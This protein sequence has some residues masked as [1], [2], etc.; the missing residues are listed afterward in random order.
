MGQTMNAQQGRYPHHD[1]YPHVRARPFATEDDEAPH[2]IAKARHACADVTAQREVLY[3]RNLLQKHAH[4]F[5]VSENELLGWI[6]ALKVVDENRSAF[7]ALAAHVGPSPDHGLGLTMTNTEQH[8][9][10]G[11]KTAQRAEREAMPDHDDYATQEATENEE[12]APD[13]GEEGAGTETTTAAPTRRGGPYSSANWFKSAKAIA[14]MR[15]LAADG[16]SGE[17]AKARRADALLTYARKNELQLSHVRQLVRAHDKIEELRPRHPEFA[18]ALETHGY[19]LTLDILAWRPEFEEE[20]LAGARRVIS[21]EIKGRDFQYLPTPEQRKRKPKGEAGEDPQPKAKDASGPTQVEMDMGDDEAAGAEPT[22]A[23]EPEAPAKRADPESP[24]SERTD[25]DLTALA[26][27]AKLA[28]GSG[29]EWI[30]ESDQHGRSLIASADDKLPKV[31]TIVIPRKLSPKHATEAR[32]S[33]A[34]QAAL[35][36]GIG[37][38][39]YVAVPTEADPK[40]VKDLMT[41]H[42]VSLGIVI[43][44]TS[45]VVE[46]HSGKVV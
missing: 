46:V 37:L 14:L 10:E 24:A 31:A 26:T 11:L 16:R 41:S 1:P 17:D 45:Q 40:A 25:Y 6:A 34:A 13:A 5:G 2:W 8:R 9:A 22:S 20:A 42:G 18:K 39:T 44:M 27:I 38:R 32:W 15:D 21:G 33:A 4:A 7:P 19:R 28:F 43:E 36:Q 29:R 23:P 3:R 12:L 35:N 30:P